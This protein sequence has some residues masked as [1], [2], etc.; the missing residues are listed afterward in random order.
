MPGQ[1]PGEALL[2]TE[3]AAMVATLAGLAPEDFTAGPTLCAGWAPRDVL[4]HLLGL[5]AGMRVYLRHGPRI[6]AANAE[7]VAAARDWSRNEL[8]ERGRRWA[9]RPSTSARVLAPALLG[10]L[11]VHHQDVLRARGI[12][13]ELPP[14]LARAVFREGL[15]LGGI[16]RLAGHRLIA[17]DGLVRPLGIGR[18]VRGPTEALGMWLAGRASARADLEGL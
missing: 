15:L 5:D 17:T 11:V 13:R 7:L 12:R 1:L 6:G 18:P 4:A 3:R 14:G 16:R 8:L 10:D 2:R 9:A